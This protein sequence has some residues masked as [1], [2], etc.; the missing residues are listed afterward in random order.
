MADKAE[1]YMSTVKLGPKGQV[2][3][4]KE[5]RNMFD[6][7]PGDSLIIMADAQRGIALQRQELLE[8]VINS[9]FQETPPSVPQEPPEN[10]RHF[11]NAVQATIEKGETRE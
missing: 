4:P 2:V 6:L 10:L 5:I 9:M 8:R 11:A 3:I 1:R 7:K